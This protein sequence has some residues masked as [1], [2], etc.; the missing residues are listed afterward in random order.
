MPIRKL[1]QYQLPRVPNF[2]IQIMPPRRRQDGFAESPKASIAEFTDDELRAIG[3]EWTEALLAHAQ[4][5]RKE[6]V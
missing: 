1:I 6:T 2:L 3:A 5:L 4:E